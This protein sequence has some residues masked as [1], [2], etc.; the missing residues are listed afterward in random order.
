MSH[1]VLPC[2][3]VLRMTSEKDHSEAPD[4]ELWDAQFEVFKTMTPPFRPHASE[5]AIVQQLVDSQPARAGESGL[6]VLILGLTPEYIGLNWPAGSRVIVVDRSSHV[7]EAWWPGD[8][9]GH[10]ELIKDDWLDMSFE[11]ASFDLIL[12]DGVF[13]FMPYPKGLRNFAAILAPLLRPGGR[14]SIRAFM[15]ADPRENTE[16]LIREYHATEAIDY[17]CFRYRLATSIQDSAEA[18]IYASKDTV[19]GI[20]LDAKVDLQEF[21]RKSG[22]TPPAVAP[23]T[24]VSSDNNYRVHYPTQ[25]QFLDSISG[26]FSQVEVRLGNYALAHRTPIFIASP[27]SDA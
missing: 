26:S 4:L 9:A 10:R 15:Q 11:R 24:K 7:A 16:V 19:D 25:Q 6:Q 13:N 27:D 21:Y 8:I 20:L 2:Q 23:L 3:A 18:G 5:V 22:H 12:G 17:Y 1:N 14:M